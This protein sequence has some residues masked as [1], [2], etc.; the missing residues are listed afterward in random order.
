VT[1]KSATELQRHGAIKAKEKVEDSGFLFTP[2]FSP[3][4][5]SNKRRGT[6]FNGFIFWLD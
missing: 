5:N 6:V 1:K 3:V 4:T 2:G